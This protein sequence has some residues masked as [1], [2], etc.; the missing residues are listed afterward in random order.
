[1]TI[2]P[3]CGTTNAEGVSFCK[4]CGHK[5]EPS[6]QQVKCSSCSQANPAGVTYCWSCGAELPKKTTAQAE[7]PVTSDQRGAPQTGTRV[8]KKCSSCGQMVDP[9]ASVCPFCSRS[10]VHYG[11]VVPIVSRRPD[12]IRLNIAGILIII[13]GIV[14]FYTSYQFF[15]AE[16]LIAEEYGIDVSSIGCCGVLEIIFG[17]GAILGGFFATTQRRFLFPLIGSILGMLSFGP[18]WIGSILA[19]IGMLL[20]VMHKDEFED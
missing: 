10:F 4:V 6:D 18:F 20:I 11:P 2:C 12:S 7:S 9:N 1:M 13:S 14:A 5:I 16:V 19:F 17:I 8:M 3:S 15:Q